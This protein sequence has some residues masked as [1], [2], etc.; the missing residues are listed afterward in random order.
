MQQRIQRRT[1][2]DKS[3]CAARKEPVFQCGGDKV[4]LV[5]IPT[6]V[7]FLFES[8]AINNHE[9]HICHSSVQRA[10][11]YHACTYI[12]ASF[13]AWPFLIYG[14]YWVVECGLCTWRKEGSLLFS[15]LATSPSS[16]STSSKFS[17]FI[18]I[19]PVW[20]SVILTGFLDYAT[21]NT[22]EIDVFWNSANWM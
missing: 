20:G 3:H 18:F 16:T 15:L 9:Y 1:Q 4:M 2:L 11:M 7:H 6:E 14:C 12:G 10:S 21:W 8:I 19:N 17:R 13:G 5:S 22:V